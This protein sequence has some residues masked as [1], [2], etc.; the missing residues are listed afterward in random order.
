MKY[1]ILIFLLLATACGTTAQTSS[2]HNPD[3]RGT[4]V[5]DATGHESA[6]ADQIIFHINLSQFHENAQSA[7][8]THKQRERYLTDLLIE[9]GFDRDAINANPIS[10][11]PRRYSNERGFETNQSISVKLNDINLFENMQVELIKNGFD[12]F[13]GRF[14]SSEEEQAR[15]TAL[16]NAVDEARK[17]AQILARA[18][19]QRVGKVLNIEFTTSS[20]PIY[21]EASAMAMSAPEDGGMLQFQTTIPIQQNVRVTFQLVD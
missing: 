5:I 7:F 3:N 4:I 13:S 19:N 9:K 1:T 21:R 8:D 10:I 15:R 20:S 14:S 16:G 12:N 6:P 2:S 18:S 17:N 11:S